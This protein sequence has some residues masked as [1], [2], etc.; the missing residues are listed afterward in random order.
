MNGNFARVLGCCGTT[1]VLF[2]SYSSIDMVWACAR[3]HSRR[4]ERRNFMG[5]RLAYRSFFFAMF[6]SWSGIAFDSLAHNFFLQPL[7]P[8]PHRL[9]L[10]EVEGRARHLERHG[11]IPLAALIVLGQLLQRG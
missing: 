11:V 7:L 9:A 4:A 8:A 6:A 2:G 1:S 10:F 3:P 5:L